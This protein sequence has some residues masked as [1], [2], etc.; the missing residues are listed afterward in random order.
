MSDNKSKET[1]FGARSSGL[2][3]TEPATR[4]SETCSGTGTPPPKS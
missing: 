1:K 2:P 3:K 4:P